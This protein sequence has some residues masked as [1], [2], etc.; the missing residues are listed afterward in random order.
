MIR[1][2]INLLDSTLIQIIRQQLIRIHQGTK[3]Q[4]SFSSTF[5][6]K[7][8]LNIRSILQK[9]IFRINRYA[10]IHSDADLN[11]VNHVKIWPNS[12]TDINTDAIGDIRVITLTCTNTWSKTKTN[13]NFNIDIIIDSNSELIPSLITVLIP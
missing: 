7:R 9:T 6:R 5:S 3:I 10:N 13:T 11:V 4:D 1:E 12:K 8:I 2:S